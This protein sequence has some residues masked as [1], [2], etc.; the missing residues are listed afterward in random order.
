[1]L[2]FREMARRYEVIGDVRGPG[3]FIGVDYVEDRATRRPATASCQKAWERA[4]DLGLVVQFGGM[5]ANVLK[6]KPPLTTPVDDFR[7]M[8]DL[9]EELTAFI[10][11]DVDRG[12]HRTILHP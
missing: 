1:T 7:K 8:L 6:F 4:V 10:Q 3:L 9:C 5:H 11:R 2:R 12:V